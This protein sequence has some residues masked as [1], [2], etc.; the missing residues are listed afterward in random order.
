LSVCVGGAPHHAGLL[1]FCTM[2]SLLITE[3]GPVLT[4]TLNRPEKR[5]A[6]N[7]DLTLM[8]REA[9]E[10]AME[11][12]DIRVVVINSRGDAFCAGADLAYLQE[13][14]NNSFDENLQDSLGLKKLFEIILKG[15]KPVIAAV[16]GAALAGGC[17]LANACDVC[18]AIPEAQFGYTETKIGFIPALV[19]IFLQRKINGSIARELLISGRLFKADEAKSLGMVHHIIPV[20][21]LDAHVMEYAQHLSKNCSGQS[22]A[23][24]KELLWNSTALGFDEGMTLAA[25]MNARA[26]AGEDCIRG[27]D[28]FLNKEKISWS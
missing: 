5:N 14:R 7:P 4:L 1:Y 13:I 11:R 24:T 20:D 25:S 27:I 3:Q 23:L 17:G 19:S 26:R 9:L 28:A 12:S 22:I 21:E 16:R 6:L 8:L 10:T 15:P 18:F 2:P